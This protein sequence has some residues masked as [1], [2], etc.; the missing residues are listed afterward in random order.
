MLKETR[1]RKSKNYFHVMN[2]VDRKGLAE[3]VDKQ[4]SANKKNKE[5]FHNFTTV[6]GTYLTRYRRA[7]GVPVEEIALKMGVSVAQL[8][9]YENGDTYI[10]AGRFFIAACYLS[11]NDKSKDKNLFFN[12]LIEELQN[13]FYETKIVSKEEIQSL[14]TT[15]VEK[16]KKRL[17]EEIMFLSEQELKKI[18]DV[19]FLISKNKRNGNV[20]NEDKANN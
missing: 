19:V 1:G 8:R 12:S 2:D 14:K 7:L 3:R 11:Y 10:S 13:L 6:L 17:D 5:I 20:K 18:Y 4:L 16:I 15:P 9:K